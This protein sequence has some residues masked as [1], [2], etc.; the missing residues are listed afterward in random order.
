MMQVRGSLNHEFHQDSGSSQWF[1]Q[2]RKAMKCSN[3]SHKSETTRQDNAAIH[4]FTFK[5]QRL[6]PAKIQKA[7]WTRVQTSKNE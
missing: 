4:L 6:D 1:P 2:Y 5:P 7:V 3:T